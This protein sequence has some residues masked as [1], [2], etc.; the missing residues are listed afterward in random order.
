M[1]NQKQNILEI[2][3][4]PEAVLLK[5]SI[6]VAKITSKEIKLFEDMLATMYASKGIGLAAAQIGRNIRIIVVDIGQGPIKLANPRIIKIKG[7]DW[8]I[9]GC[10]SVPDISVNIKRPTE[11]VV[12][13][14]NEKGESV[15]IKASGLLSRVIQHEIDHLNGKLIVDYLGLLSKL[16]MLKLKRGI[17]C[18]Q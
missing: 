3:K 12:V 5:K 1:T 13:A 14:L 6:P 10:L 2:K 7:K 15:E 16:R 17:K 8:L 9:E 11:I 18:K 4:Y